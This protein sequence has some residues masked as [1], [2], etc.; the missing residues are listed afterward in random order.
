M[1]GRREGWSLVE[2]TVG[3]M[4]GTVALV[5][6]A[7][8]MIS[9]SHLQALTLSR[10][11][12]ATVGEAKLDQLRSHAAL[13]TTDTVKLSAGGSLSSDVANHNELV[14]TARGR[15]YTVR[16]TVAS[17]LNGTRDVTVRVLPTGLRKNEVPYVDLNTLM[18]I[19]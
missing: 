5:A 10:M 18:L 2:T 4:V 15:T 19:R 8:V 1:K 9:T 7:G 14:T 12:L 17:G 3:M 6:L 16:W 13:Q 11:E